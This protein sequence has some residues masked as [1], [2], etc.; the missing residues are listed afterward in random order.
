M[1]INWGMENGVLMHKLLKLNDTLHI[2]S[3]DSITQIFSYPCSH[4]E[5]KNP[6]VSLSNIPSAS[7]PSKPIACRWIS[8]CLHGTSRNVKGFK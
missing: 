2:K 4:K 1:E 7:F 6:L 8:S 5:S 3:M